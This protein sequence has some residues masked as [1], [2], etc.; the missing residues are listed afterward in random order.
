MFYAVDFLIEPVFYIGDFLVKA[1]FR[2]YQV[3]PSRGLRLQ[4]L[5]KSFHLGLREPGLYEFEGWKSAHAVFPFSIFEIITQSLRVSERANLAQT[6]GEPVPKVA[7]DRGRWEVGV[8]HGRE[9]GW[10]AVVLAPPIHR[11]RAVPHR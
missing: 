1:V 7:Q 5:R 9:K 11:R 4:E 8:H 3:G 10:A 2:T 6:L